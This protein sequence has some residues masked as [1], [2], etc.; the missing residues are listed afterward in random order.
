MYKNILVDFIENETKFSELRRD[1]R[2]T[3]VVRSFSLI[4]TKLRQKKGRRDTHTLIK[5]ES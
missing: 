1:R 3:N 4:L 5:V 2:N